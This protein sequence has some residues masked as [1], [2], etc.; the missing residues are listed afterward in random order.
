MLISEKNKKNLK[1]KEKYFL[2][3]NRLYSRRYFLRKK[4]TLEIVSTYTQIQVVSVEQIQKGLPAL[5]L[6]VL[7]TEQDH[8][9]AHLHSTFPSS[10]PQHLSDGWLELRTSMCCKILSRYANYPEISLHSTHLIAAFYRCGC[11]FF[12][13]SIFEIACVSQLSRI[14]LQSLADHLF[15]FFCLFMFSLV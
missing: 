8:P 10:V 14:F 15:F 11:W 4:K 9:S 13:I 2:C 3:P 12:P 1:K 5:G 7:I 6:S